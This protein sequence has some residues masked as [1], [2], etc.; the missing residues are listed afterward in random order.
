MENKWYTL[1]ENTPICYATGKWDGK[2]SDWILVELKD[3]NYVVARVYECFMDGHHFQE[4]YYG[5][6]QYEFDSKDIRRW[7]YIPD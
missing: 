1:E 2:R 7:R 6:E 3:L 5:I 4:W